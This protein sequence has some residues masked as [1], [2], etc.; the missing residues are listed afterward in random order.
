MMNLY[1]LAP[2]F[3]KD[4]FNLFNIGLIPYDPYIP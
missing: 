2:Y 3:K 1:S 4:L